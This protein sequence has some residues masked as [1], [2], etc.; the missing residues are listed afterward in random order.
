[1]PNSPMPRPDE[2]VRLLR[3]PATDLRVEHRRAEQGVEVRRLAL[4]QAVL[5][6]AVGRD[7]DPEPGRGRRTDAQRPK[8]GDP[9]LFGRA[10]IGDL[11]DFAERRDEG[12]RPKRWRWPRP[13]LAR[14]G[15]E[16]GCHPWQL[17][18]RDRRGGG[19]ADPQPSA[20]WNRTGE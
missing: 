17:P 1:M 18:S 20:R 3:I 12:R 2:P 5:A 4:G 7:V 15:Q 19:V 11:P 9:D 14:G 13:E 6:D 8:G 10:G 16:P